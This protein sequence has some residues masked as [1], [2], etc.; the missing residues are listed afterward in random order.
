[1]K[2]L[3][4]AGSGLLLAAPLLGLAQTA[5]AAAPRYYAG[6]G[7][8]S[9]HFQKLGKWHNGD[10]TGFRLPVQLAAGY[11]LRPRLALELGAAYSGITTTY[12]ITADYSHNSFFNPTGITPYTYQ[13]SNTTTEGLV[14]ISTLARYTLPHRLPSRLH[15]A[16]LGGFTLEH[17]SIYSR[18]F[19]GDDLSGTLQTVPFSRRFSFD[20]LLLT[21]GLGLRCRLTQSTELNYHFTENRLIATSYPGIA[22]YTTTASHAL[23]LRYSFGQH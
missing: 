6:L 17:Q 2:L 4:L 19:E 8:Y 20:N 16:A 14:S 10:K 23:G 15:L 11:Q 5:P 3:L 18:G 13:Y 22:V 7:V 9:S 12:A 1:M 21:V